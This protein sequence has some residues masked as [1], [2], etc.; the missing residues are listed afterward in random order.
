[1][2]GIYFQTLIYSTNL[3]CIRLD[4]SLNLRIDLTFRI[5]DAD[6]QKISGRIIQIFT[7]PIRGEDTAFFFRNSIYLYIIAKLY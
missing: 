2:M 6:L 4:H 3:N 7:K 5:F 1:M